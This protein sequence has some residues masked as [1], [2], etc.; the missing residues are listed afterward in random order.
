MSARRPHAELYCHLIW[1][2]W[3]RRAFITPNIEVRLYAAIRTKLES[4]TC[5]EISIGGMPD[6]VHV[7]CR[8]PPVLSV[9]QLVQQV[10]GAS[11]HLAT[12]ELPGL[13]E[14]KWQ[15]G[16][17]AFTLS[18]GDLPRVRLYVAEQKQ[19]HL[20]QET[21]VDYERTWIEE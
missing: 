13:E 17:G 8:F 16:Y 12:H 11:S 2:T 21:W 5:S 15:G 19:H 10:K 6:H 3:D 14:F 20:Q 4:L 18:S 9:S 7:V 1:A